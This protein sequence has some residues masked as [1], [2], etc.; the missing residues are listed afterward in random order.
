MA[1]SSW[2]IKTPPLRLCIDLLAVVER[3]FDPVLLGQTMF[4]LLLLLGSQVVA[5]GALIVSFGQMQHI[6]SPRH[7][8]WREWF[9]AQ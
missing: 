3:L 5:D 1:R 8:H 9:G 2:R 4:R 7:C 6:T